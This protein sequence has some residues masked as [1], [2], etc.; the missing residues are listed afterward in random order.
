MLSQPTSTSQ[1]KMMRTLTPARGAGPRTMPRINPPRK[2]RHRCSKVPRQLG[3]HR[4]PTEN[5]DHEQSR[6]YWDDGWEVDRANSGAEIQAQ[7]SCGTEKRGRAM[8]RVQ[9]Q[10][11][12][13]GQEEKT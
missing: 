4:L 5:R 9:V 6:A 12:E 8:R 7:G 2:T 10:Y 1:P 13:G 3:N 11:R